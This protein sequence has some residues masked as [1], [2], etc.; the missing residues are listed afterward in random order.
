M[1]LEKRDSLLLDHILTQF[2]YDFDSTF[3]VRSRHHFKNQ[4]DLLRQDTAQNGGSFRSHEATFKGY[5]LKSFIFDYQRKPPFVV[6]IT[7]QQDQFVTLFSFTDENF[8]SRNSIDR[9]M[10]KSQSPA[11][12]TILAE[13]KNLENNLNGLIDKFNLTKKDEIFDLTGKL[14]KVLN[15]APVSKDSIQTLIKNLCSNTDLK[16]GD[17][18]CNL[19]Y[20]EEAS[21]FEKGGDEVLMVNTQSYLGFWRFWIEEVNGKSFIRAAFFSDIL[22]TPMYM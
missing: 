9:R 19:V 22:Y 3:L 16:W 11:Q 14:C 20:Q 10:N 6:E 18:I 8:Y 2:D 17:S 1:S 13:K 7:N 21:F 15:M 4:L 12:D 5:R